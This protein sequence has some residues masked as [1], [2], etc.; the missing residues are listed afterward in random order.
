LKTVPGGNA[1]IPIVVTEG[2]R[3]TEVILVPRN[4]RLSMLLTLLPNVTVFKEAQY[5]K[6]SYS[7]DVTLPGI[8]KEDSEV[9]PENIEKL[10]VF[11]VL[12]KVTD[13]R[14]EQ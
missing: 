13:T 4:A 3:A 14:D 2:G 5:A 10:I 6:S 12:D 11:R 9:H 8:V 7:I 1:S